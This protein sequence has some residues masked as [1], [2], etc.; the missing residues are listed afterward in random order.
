MSR[1]SSHSGIPAF[2]HSNILRQRRLEKATAGIIEA[3]ERRMLMS[4]TT[5]VVQTNGDGIDSPPASLHSPHTYYARTLRDAVAFA[6]T[7]SYSSTITFAGAVVGQTITLLQTYGSL[8]LMNSAEGILIEGQVASGNP[9]ITV[10][11]GG[12]V[13]VFSLNG[14]ATASFFGLNVTGGGGNGSGIR[15]NSGATIPVI[16]ACNVSSNTSTGAGGGIFNFGT[17]DSITSCTIN[18]NTTSD[19]GGGIYNGNSGIIQ[20][21]QQCQINGDSCTGGSSVGGGIF[22]SGTMSLTSV[23]V[24]SNRSESDGGGILDT[25]NSYMWLGNDTVSGNYAGGDGAGIHQGGTLTMVG[26]SLSDNTC[27]ASGT[28]GGG[29]KLDGYAYFSG[30]TV[31]NNYS[32]E[33]GGIWIGVGNQLVI[34]SSNVSGNRALQIGGGIGTGDADIYGYGDTLSGNTAEGDG[35]DDSND[36]GG[37]IYARGNLT[38]TFCKINSNVSYGQGGGIFSGANTYLGN[39]TIH[40]N[41]AGEGGENNDGGGIKLQ[42]GGTMVA[43]MVGDNTVVGGD[44]EGGGIVVGSEFQ[45]TNCSVYSDSVTGAGGEGG[46]IFNNGGNG[47][48][49]NCQIGNNSVS[50]ADGEGGG[51]T[52]TGGILIDNSTVND[53]SVS[54]ADGQGGGILT[55]NP[56]SLDNCTISGDSASGT[57]GEGGGICVVSSGNLSL[58]GSTVSDDSASGTDGEGGGIFTSATC[59][60]DNC[61]ISGDSASGTDGEGGGIY[62]A[63]GGNLTV[64][65]STIGTDNPAF[66][67]GDAIFSDTATKGGGIFNDGF[68]AYIT[69]SHV[70]DDSATGDGGG[71]FT[72]NTIGTITHTTISDDSSGGKGGG[73]FLPSTG[74][75]QT[76]TFCQIEG[77]KAADAGGGLYDAGGIDSGINYTTISGDSV[78]SGDGGGIYA[79]AYLTVRYSTIAGD[80]ASGDGG[81]IF[82]LDGQF[83]LYNSTIANDGATGGRGGGLD[84]ESPDTKIGDC[85]ISGDSAGTGGGVFLNTNYVYVYNTIIAGNTLSHVTTASDVSVAGSDHFDYSSSYNLV[86]TGGNGGLVGSIN[87]LNVSTSDLDLSP[88]GNFGGPTPTMPPLVGSAALSSGANVVNLAYDQRGIGFVSLTPGETGIDVGAFQLGT[89]QILTVNTTSGFSVTGTTLSL[90]GALSM[91]STPFDGATV[92]DFDPTVFAS[93]Q[94]ITLGGGVGNTATVYGNFVTLNVPTA[95]LT[96]IGTIVNDGIL[97]IVGGTPG[98]PLTLGAAPGTAAAIAAITGTGALVLGN[99]TTSTYLQLS[100]VT[101]GTGGTLAS[102]QNTQDAL[103]MSSSSCLN[104]TNNAFLINYGANDDPI[105]DIASYMAAGYGSGGEFGFAGTVGIVSTGSQSTT[106]LNAAQSAMIYSIGYADGADGIATGLSSGQIEIMATLAGD[107]KMQGEV[108]FGDFQLLDEYFGVSGGWDDGNFRFESVVVFGDYELISQNFDDNDAGLF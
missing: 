46:G 3:L 97:N 6:N 60:L 89:A 30:V 22:N 66:S 45:L 78:T 93:L 98:D 71:I 57:G 54:G 9:D 33:G 61:T 44:G 63:S 32:F 47:T 23:S 49:S 50:G 38:L 64:D 13:G 74:Q 62:L 73:I 72:E 75:I 35:F 19:S 65:D 108:D 20:S 76:L 53:N 69:G 31:T 79:A 2:R 70:D 29:M 58:V 5:I 100:P 26:G 1:L 59:L 68:I 51:I 82:D 14:G 25:T 107:A 67:N 48:L 106:S 91:A 16:T 104:V 41:T 28:A 10:S 12:N 15:N 101:A 95:G 87:M 102:V 94:T 83:R 37:A 11:G 7:N 43:C 90:E 103:A 99:A 85:T 88:L 21:I 18:S 55:T 42:N 96:I 27:A 24:S 86:G 56:C 4:V 80:S 36:G 52:T 34:N 39:D 84:L 8:Q 40:G 77:D 92:I 17:I 105:G 81:G